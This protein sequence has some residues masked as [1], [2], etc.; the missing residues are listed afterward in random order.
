MKVFFIWV[1]IPVYIEVKLPRSNE[2]KKVQIK[3]PCS[4]ADLMEKMKVNPDTCL[5]LINKKPVPIDT[6]VENKQEIELIEVTSGG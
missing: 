5:T 2:I 3:G 6:F 4:I 1:S